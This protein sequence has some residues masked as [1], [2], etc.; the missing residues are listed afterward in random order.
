MPFIIHSNI[1]FKY[2]I[3]KN[4]SALFD[5]PLWYNHVM[6]KDTGLT[7]LVEAGVNRFEPENTGVSRY[8]NILNELHMANMTIREANHKALTKRIREDLLEDDE[9]GYIPDLGSIYEHRKE[10]YN[11]LRQTND[12][13]S[14]KYPSIDEKD[15]PMTI[16]ARITDMTTEPMA[17]EQMTIGPEETTSNFMEMMTINQL[18]QPTTNSN[19]RNLTE[20]MNTDHISNTVRSTYYDYTDEVNNS[21]LNMD[22]DQIM[23]D[24]ERNLHLSPVASNNSE[25]GS[26]HENSYEYQDFTEDDRITSGHPDFVNY[27]A[28]DL[29]DAIELTTGGG[30]EAFRNLFSTVVD[31][32]FT[33]VNRQ[34]NYNSNNNNITE[35]PQ[36]QEETDENINNTSIICLETDNNIVNSPKEEPFY[37]LYEKMDTLNDI[38]DISHNFLGF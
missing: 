28:D 5:Q 24:C 1:K 2:T 31:E 26:E 10:I 15:L 20:L 22:L 35:L 16:R 23:D 17:T 27:V 14:D 13:Y 7:C 19:D 8:R 3:L 18:N 21:D 34:I 12:K 36:N 38:I 33:D 29:I 6:N 4:P 37:D 9:V 30:E 11:N 25:Y 32:A